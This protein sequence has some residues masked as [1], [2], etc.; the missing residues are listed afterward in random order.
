[1]SKR[2]RDYL[3]TSFIVLFVVLTLLISLYASGYK[4][5]LSLPI[6]FDRLLIETGMLVID[7]TPKGAVIYL[8]DK[9]QKTAGWQLKKKGT[10]STP[11]KIKNLV[12]GEYSLL[13]GKDDYWPIKKVIKIESGQTTFIENINLFKINL[14]LQIVTSSLENITISP[15]YKYIFVPSDKKVINL[16]NNQ[17]IFLNVE[18]VS[19]WKWLKNGSRLAIDGLIIDPENGNN[20]SDYSQVIGVDAHN[21]LWDEINNYLYYINKDSLNRLEASGQTNSVIVRGE[22]YLDYQP[23]NNGIFLVTQDNNKTKI[24]EYSTQKQMVTKEIELPNAG[25]YHFISDN[26]PN[27]LSLYDER[28]KTLRLFQID[29]I[30]ENN[31]TIKNIKTWQ[32]LSDYQ[33]VYH[34][35]FEIYILDTRQD[36]ATLVTRIGEEIKKIIYNDEN[37]YLI[38]ATKDSIKVIDFR[39]DNITTL[40]KG[41][42]GGQI[43][44]SV[45]D[46]K[47]NTVYFTTKIGQQQGVYQILVK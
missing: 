30:N 35:D 13:L 3:L 47:N 14:P 31:L 24:K 23:S 46:E 37:N 26:N 16:R 19:S 12:P 39:D 15:N 11:N 7:T 18:S 2:I 29:K 45:L 4:I 36:S 8:D 20:I 10:L 6:K 17:E 9:A 1:M 42:S 21:W 22:N 5:N 40:F 27:W 44:S 43:F 34:N 41:V 32:W 33:L 25:N 38:V 28:N